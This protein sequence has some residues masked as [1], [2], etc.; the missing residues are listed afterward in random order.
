MSPTLDQTACL[1]IRQ[2]K[3]NLLAQA[4]ETKKPRSLSTGEAKFWTHE[5]IRWPN[6][7]TVYKTSASLFGCGRIIDEKIGSCRIFC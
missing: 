2:A 3:K 5:C 4:D 1:Q 6:L 7:N